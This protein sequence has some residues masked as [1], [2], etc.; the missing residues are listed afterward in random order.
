MDSS[1]V[2]HNTERWMGSFKTDEEA[3]RELENKVA[4]FAETKRIVSAKK[5][6]LERHP[7]GLLLYKF[8]VHTSPK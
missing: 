8:C 2:D 7:R 3:Q 4:R 5:E 1:K 6:L